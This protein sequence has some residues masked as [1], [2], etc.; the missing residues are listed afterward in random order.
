MLISLAKEFSDISLLAQDWAEALLPKMANTGTRRL[1]T[2]VRVEIL[3]VLVYDRVEKSV[4][5]VFQW[6]FNLN[7]SNRRTSR[8][9]HLKADFAL[10]PH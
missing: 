9:Y 3:Q 4:F 6:N 5:Q 8:L 2:Y 7:I 1:H 10:N